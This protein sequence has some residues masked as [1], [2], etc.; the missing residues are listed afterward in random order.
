[1]S[2]WLDQPAG[3]PAASA[4]TAT[5]APRP[6]VAIHSTEDGITIAVDSGSGKPQIFDYEAT[7]DGRDLVDIL[8]ACCISTDYQV[9]EVE[10]D[11][12]EDLSGCE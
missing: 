6:Q 11:Q 9:G 1:V 12:G 8:R 10:P 5:G 7:L 2:A 4:L 3:K